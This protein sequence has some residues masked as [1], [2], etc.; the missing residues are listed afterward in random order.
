[1]TV[2]EFRTQP[3]ARRPGC[4]DTVFLQYLELAKICPEFPVD[5][6]QELGLHPPVRH[7]AGLGEFSPSRRGVFQKAKDLIRAIARLAGFRRGRVSTAS[8]RGKPD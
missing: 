6:R 4:D 3:G 7:P 5:R 1:M 8:N 2:D